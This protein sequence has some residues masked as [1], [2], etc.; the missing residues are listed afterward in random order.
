[1]GGD[2]FTLAFIRM[3]GEGNGSH[4]ARRGGRAEGA[5]VLGGD[6][7]GR[8]RVRREEGT[9]ARLKKRKVRARQAS[10]PTSLRESSTVLST[11]EARYRVLPP[12]NRKI[13]SCSCILP[14]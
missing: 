13:Y 11:D 7:V 10:V 12:Q 9:R 6:R 5:V 14:L 4:L 1:V 2:C 8:R 3:A